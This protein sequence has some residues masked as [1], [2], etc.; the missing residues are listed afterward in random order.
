MLLDAVGPF[1]NASFTEYCT[2]HVLSPNT[3]IDFLYRIVQSSVASQQKLDTGFV[4]SICLNSC[5]LPSAW[6]AAWSLATI[7][8]IDVE[9]LREIRSVI[10]DITCTP[11]FV[12]MCSI[13]AWVCFSLPET[14]FWMTLCKQLIPL[15]SNVMG[16]LPLTNRIQFA[17]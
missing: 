5:Y 17:V 2:L 8:V 14:N 4:M 9:N 10:F 6:S 1:V 11:K 12:L 3:A 13:L 7:S 16:R 15:L